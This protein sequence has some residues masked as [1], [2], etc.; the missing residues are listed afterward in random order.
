M[1][2]Y[3]L[4][5]TWYDGKHSHAKTI[6]FWS[7]P[8]NHREKAMTEFMHSFKIDARYTSRVKCQWLHGNGQI[9]IPPGKLYEIDYLNAVEPVWIC[10]DDSGIVAVTHHG[11][12]I[13]YAIEEI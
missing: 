2:L 1:Y 12:D 5:I 11:E 6:R 10:K 4:V 9:V 13:P 7:F 8:W 3:E